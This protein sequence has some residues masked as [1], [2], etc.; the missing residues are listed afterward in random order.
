MSLNTSGLLW[1]LQLRVLPQTGE[2]WGLWGVVAQPR[3]QP[4]PVEPALCA[5][6]GG[7]EGRGL[8]Q[9]AARDDCCYMERAEV[10]SMVL[11]GA[12]EEGPA[13]AGQEVDRS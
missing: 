11:V 9:E 8:L 13:P 4:D 12:A 2:H 6:E 7:R 1:G 10:I 5:P 3:V